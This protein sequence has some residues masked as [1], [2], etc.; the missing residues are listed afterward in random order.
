MNKAASIDKR[1]HY[2]GPTIFERG[3]RPFFFFAGLWGI[4][5]L[6]LWLA[7]YFGMVS[8]GGAINPTYW[9]VHEMLFGYAG[10]A[11]IGF[12]LTA[13]PNWTG[14]LP[15]RGTAL[16]I[17]FAAWAAARITSAFSLFYPIEF[18]AMILDGAFFVL[19]SLIVFREIMVGENWRNLPIALM[20]TLIGTM[21]VLSHIN[22]L[23]WM[24]E[25]TAV[26][27]GGL[28]LVILLISL[29]GGRI[30][31]S[32]TRNWLSQR[33]E[34]TLPAPA[35]KFDMFSLILT[36]VTLITW[37]FMTGDNIV[38][39]LLLI[40]TGAVGFIR[41]FRWVGHKTFAE[42]LVIILHV[43]FAWVPIGFFMLAA[44]CMG[45]ISESTAVHTWTA[46]AIAGM[47][48]AVM[49]RASLGHSGRPLSADKCITTLY[50][51][52]TLAAVMRLVAGIVDASQTYL[53]I[54][55]GLWIA[56]FLLFLWRF[57]PIFFKPRA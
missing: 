44:S 32:F 20:I 36:L 34:K 21:A 52:I 2:S 50:I 12:A 47:T 33:R 8:A 39:F 14:R 17:L 11:I 25:Y 16:F 7:V 6:A 55:G 4:I 28:S 53:M 49:T 54:A 3:Y 40:T 30:I 26:H 31:P 45:L 51:A 38:L 43:A 9:H 57:T 29:I 56:A 22:S 18:A 1:R 23:Y 13:I 10:S 5:P 15:V 42:P 41:L 37:T 24:M 19:F 48:L 35:S 46:G 27:K